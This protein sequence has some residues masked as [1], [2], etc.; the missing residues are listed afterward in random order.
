MLSFFFPLSCSYFPFRINA[1]IAEAWCSQT[2]KTHTRSE[3][4][5]SGQVF[6][7]VSAL[8]LYSYFLNLGRWQFHCHVLIGKLCAEGQSVHVF[9]SLKTFFFFLRLCGCKMLNLGRTQQLWLFFVLFK[10]C[11]S[12]WRAHTR[13]Q[14]AVCSWCGPSALLFARDVVDN[15]LGRMIQ[16]YFLLTLGWIIT[17][18]R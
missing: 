11:D 3:K 16:Y 14:P 4:P 13:P 9:G 10:L 8:S 15:K 17:W 2:I 1:S 5:A 6:L 18:H 12:L 7:P